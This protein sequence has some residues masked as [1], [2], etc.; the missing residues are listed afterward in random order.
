MVIAA[1]DESKCTQRFS[2]ERWV[3]RHR[4]LLVHRVRIIFRQT[5]VV[6]NGIFCSNIVN[7]SAVFVSGMCE[8]LNFLAAILTLFYAC[9]LRCTTGINKTDGKFCHRFNWYCWYRQQI[10]TT[11]INDTGSKFA[12][13]VR[14]IMGKISGCRHLKVNLKAK[15]YIHICWLY[16]PKVSKQNN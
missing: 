3:D 15:I 14:Q 7:N 6:G 2:R 11:G 12:T 13:G 9:D 5:V 4:S 1:S 8:H 10:A 16:Y